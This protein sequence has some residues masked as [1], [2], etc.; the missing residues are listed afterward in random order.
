MPPFTH[1][2]CALQYNSAGGD[3]AVV[4]CYNLALYVT[5]NY[6]PHAPLPAGA[7]ALV[8]G[9]TV[10]RLR[11]LDPRANCG[12]RVAGTMDDSESRYTGAYLMDVGLIWPTNTPFDSRVL[13]LQRR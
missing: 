5:A 9:S 12:V 4:F 2:R 1:N 10:W 11:G 6:L 7:Q 13:I 3:S 8:R